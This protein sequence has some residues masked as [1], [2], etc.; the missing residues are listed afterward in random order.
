MS[1]AAYL[2]RKHVAINHVALNL[3][4]AYRAI[5]HMY[6]SDSYISGDEETTGGGDMLAYCQHHQ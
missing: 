3:F 6:I 4:M 5:R 1:A 2:H